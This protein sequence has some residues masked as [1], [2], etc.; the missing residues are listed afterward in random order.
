M[1]QQQPHGGQAG[2]GSGARVLGGHMQ[3]A[4]HDSST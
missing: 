4:A 3:Q 1:D 2:S